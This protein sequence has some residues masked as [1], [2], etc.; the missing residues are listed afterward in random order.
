VTD[1]DK[2]YS[3]NNPSDKQSQSSK[4]GKTNSDFTTDVNVDKD[5]KNEKKMS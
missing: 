1:K 4:S 2:N 5:K 3:P